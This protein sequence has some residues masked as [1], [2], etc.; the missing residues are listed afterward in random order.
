MINYNNI[1]NYCDDSTL[2]NNVLFSIGENIGNTMITL[3]V[4]NDNNYICTYSN[5]WLYLIKSYHSNNH[6]IYNSIINFYNTIIHKHNVSIINEETISFITSFSTG[7]VHGY[8]GLFYIISEYINNIELYKNKKILVAKNS[9]QGILDIIN[10]LSNRNI[11][12]KN[13]I[14]YLD[15]N[16]IYHIQ[17]ILFI[18]NKCHIFNDEL[19]NK[20]TNI[21]NKY[22]ICDRIDINYMK[23]LNLPENLNKICIIKGSNSHNLTASGVIPQNNVIN[24]ANKWNITLVEPS[25]INEIVLIHIISKCKIFVTT[26]GTAFLKNYIYV[27]D[28]CTN[29]IV[30]VVGEDFINQYNFYLNTNTLLHKYKNANIIYKIVNIDLNFNPF[31]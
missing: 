25:I 4:K 14:I 29:I 16:I 18:P 15:K 30:I 26:W 27:S 24:F 9:Q 13:N 28:I 7:T 17:S 10:H 6:N 2:C 23:S 5:E 20:V 8:S 11:I 31:E 1:F 12:N 19:C 22:I 21:V 3:A